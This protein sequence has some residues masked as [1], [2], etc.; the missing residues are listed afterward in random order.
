MEMLLFDAFSGEPHR[1]ERT[2]H[3]HENS[4]IHR[5]LFNSQKP[6]DDIKRLWHESQWRVH[7]HIL[8]VQTWRTKIQQ[9]RKIWFRLFQVIWTEVFWL[10]LSP[11]RRRFW[12]RSPTWF[13]RKEHEKAK[14]HE[15]SRRQLGCVLGGLKMKGSSCWTNKASRKT[16]DAQNGIERG[17]YIQSSESSRF[18]NTDGLS[19]EIER[20]RKKR[21]K[22]HEVKWKGVFG[23]G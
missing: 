12:R 22:S 2:R 19:N 4:D 8:L 10:E 21:G 7:Q 1:F 16:R 11:T 18:E 6:P 5:P 9:R 13:Y 17:S 23:S 20:G 3:S 14:V 15:T